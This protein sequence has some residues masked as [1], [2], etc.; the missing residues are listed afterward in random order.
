[1]CTLGAPPTDSAAP[2]PV[3]ERT[4][5]AAG[6]APSEEGGEP[7]PTAGIEPA[8][9]PA[10]PAIPEARRLTLE[11]P[12][13]I[14]AGDSDIIRLTLE[15]DDLGSLTPTAHI[16]G[17]VIAGDRVLIPNLFDTHNVIAEARLDLAGMLVSPAETTSEP[18]LPG[19]PVRFF[20][21]V[22]PEGSGTYRGTAWLH[23]RFVDKVSGEE[24]RMAVSAQTLEL[25]AVNFFG[26]SA[27]F[28][29]GAGAIGSLIGGIL[30]FPFVD[31]LIKYLLRRIKR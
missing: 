15:V 23:L 22:R 1:M 29:R 16:Q 10:R 6:E 14:R 25:E 20:W 17:N 8:D 3:A 30:G 4:A 2:E 19:K 7:V 28:T 26:F 27:D 11:F 9:E 12:A 5:P 21:S 24:S 18:L 31:D 13:R